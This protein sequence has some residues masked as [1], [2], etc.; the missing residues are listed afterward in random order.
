MTEFLFFSASAGA[1]AVLNGPKHSDEV[2]SR[3]PKHKRAVLDLMEKIQVL[4]K[5]CSGGSYSTVDL[6]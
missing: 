2:L 4:D 5:L 3:I 1:F 6:N